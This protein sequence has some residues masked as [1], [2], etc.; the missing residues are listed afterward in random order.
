[1]AAVILIF[2]G[3]RYVKHCEWTPKCW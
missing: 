3:L 1:M 2:L